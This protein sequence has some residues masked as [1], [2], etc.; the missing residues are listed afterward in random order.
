MA[1]MPFH[2][3]FVRHRWMLWQTPW[4]L[5]G[6][7]MHL[8]AARCGSQIS[9]FGLAFSWAISTETWCFFLG[10]TYDIHDL[11][12]TYTKMIFVSYLNLG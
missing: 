2:L 1:S 11:P 7:N 10:S 6:F 3:S 9:P 12:H 4:K 5:V 8:G